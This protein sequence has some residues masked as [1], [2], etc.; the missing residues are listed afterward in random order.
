MRKLFFFLLVI[1]SCSQLSAQYYFS[2][3]RYYE[4][5]VLYEFG[6]KGGLMNAMT[7]LGGKGGGIVRKGLMKD[8]RWNTAR[9]CFGAYMMVTYNHAISGRIEGTTGTV[10]GFDSVLKRYG[11]ADDVRFKR[12]QSFRSQVSELS[13]GIEIHPMIIFNSEGPL[14]KLSPYIVIG[15]GYFAFNP[16]AK[17]GNNWYALKPLHTEGQNFAEYPDRKEYDLH[18]YNLSG[19]FGLRMEVGSQFNARLEFLN[20]KLFTDY[21]D[22]VSTTY[23]DPSLFYKYLNPTVASVAEQLA[24][25][26]KEINPADNV[27]PGDPRGNP[28]KND[29]Y[30]TLEFKLGVILGRS[31]R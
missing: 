28:K 12:N 14:Q 27:Q 22:D 2:D 21:L 20:R 31:R 15:A 30:F 29:S 4:S 25:R 18:Q 1:L 6:I 3:D 9:P 11:D 23:I 8:L 7:D 13:L 10:I 16:E 17:L 26:R 19:G 24:N 5:P